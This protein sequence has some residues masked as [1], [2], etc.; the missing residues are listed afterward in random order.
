MKKF[1]AFALGLM[2]VLAACAP[3]V[4]ATPTTAPAVA[5]P[6]TVPP[7]TPAIP[8]LILATTTSTQD[9][10]LLDD[11]IPLFE[12]QTGFTIQVVAVGS[13]AAMK[14]GQEGN[15]DVLLV[16]SPSAEKTFM[17]DGWGSE[18]YLVMHNNFIIVGP[19]SDP[20]GVKSATSTV[21]AFTRIATAKAPFVTRGDG[22]GTN[23]KELAIWKSAG[24]T[25]EGDWYINTGQGMGASLTIASEKSAYTI[26][27]DATFLA[28]QASYTLTAL[29]QGDA[30][31]L[32]VYHV[33]VVNPDKWPK[34]NNDGAKTFAAWI[35]SPEIQ[36]VIG[37]FGTS[38]YGK[39]LFTPDATKTDADLGLK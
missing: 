16:H 22:S 5:Q 32:N 21:D 7:T 1:F 37:L 9:S 8:Q 23:T 3:A 34:V 18:R 10:G 26:T 13:G 25:P 38:K 17:T 4:V 12:K 6:T 15:A 24:I 28:N 39:P 35:V 20:A 27:D 11:L 29:Y 2:V 14:M 19:A 30:A 31:L 33:I 36:T